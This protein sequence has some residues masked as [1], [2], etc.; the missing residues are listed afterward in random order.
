MCIRD[1]NAYDPQFTVDG[2]YDEQAAQAAESL[3]IELCMMMKAAR[4]AFKI[5]KHV[6]NYPHCWRTDKP[7]LYYPLDS[8]F[9]RSTACKERMI[10]LNKTINWK[11]ESTGTGRFGKWL[12]NLNDWNLSRS[13]Y[14]GTPLPIWRTEDNSEEKC[15]ESVEELYNEIEKSVAAGLMQSNPY[16]EKGFQPGVYTKEN[17]DK[18]DLHRPYVDDVILVSKDGK[19]MKRETDLIDVW[20]DSG[21]MP[22]AQI[23]YPFENKELLDSHQVYPADFIAEGVDQT[24]GW[25]FTLHAIATMVFDSISY[26]AVIS[27]GLVLD[28]NGNKMS[29]RLGNAVDPFSTI[30][31]YGSD[32]LRWYMITNSSPWD[33][34]K[35]DVDGVEEV[36]RKFFGT[37]YNTYSFFALYANVDEFEYKEAD[38]PM[39]E[40]PEIDRWILSVLNT[41]VKNVDTCYNEYEPTKA[42]RLISEFVNDNLSNWYVR[43]NR[44]RFWGGGMTQD[45]LSAFQTLYTCLETVA[46]LMAPIAPFYADMLYSDL[47]AATGRDNVVSVHLAKFPEYKEEMI[48][49]GLE[50]RM[51]MAQDVTSMVLALRRKVNIKVRQPLQCIMIPVVDEEQRAHIEAVKA[52]IMNEVN[53]KE[54]Q[55]VDGA[56]GVLVKKVKCDFKKLG[57]KF[58]KQMKAVAAAVAEMSQEAIAELEKKGSYTFNLDGAEAVIETAD[59]EIFSEDIPGWLVANEG[60]LTVALEVTVTEELRREGIAREL[61]NRI[62]NIRKSSGFEITDKIKITLSKNPQTDDAVNEYN[63]YIRNQVLGTS[64]TLADNVENGTELNFDDFSLYVSVVKE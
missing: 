43:L 14:W 61:V 28:K 64:L 6:H 19:P 57:P 1:R 5:E 25:F 24:R 53:V 51:Q 40:R 45:K 62:Q 10:E 38:V 56:A 37:L 49:K 15:I 29:K 48:D 30:E 9:I 2:K 47:I 33:N 17:Y 55:F 16:K 18:I 60:K 23:H 36:R 8:W 7:V 42:G 59:V 27:N 20:F 39:T 13:R 26:K 63:D 58:G 34:L 54:I 44:K 50:V 21:A 11:P 31:K 32:P 4:Q 12:E 35:F 52:L 22:Y 46:K 41:L 3:D